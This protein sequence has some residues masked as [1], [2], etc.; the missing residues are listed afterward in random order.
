MKKV[1]FL[2]SAA[3]ALGLLVVTLVGPHLV[4]Y[5]PTETDYAHALQAP[6]QDHLFGTDHL[7]RD[8]FSR[9]IC[10]GE[11]SLRMT[12]LLLLLVFVIGTTIGVASGYL[13]GP[14]DLAVMQLCDVFL[15]FPGILLAVAVAGILGPSSTNVVLALV[16]VS[17]AKYARLSRSVVLEIKTRAYLETAR[18]GGAPGATVLVRYVLPNTIPLLVITAA[19]DVGTLLLEIASLSFLGLG[20]PPPTPEWGAM[21]NEGRNFLQTA[22]WL[23]LFPGLALLLTVTVFNLLGEAV[24]DI[25]DPYQR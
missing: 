7:G 17:W 21:I 23:M 13:G 22:P 14:F 15:S 9:L 25:W 16:L 20:M 8:L 12:F 6:D 4:P 24:R 11:H 1:R 19:S 18:M 3:L 2:I 5:S 10:G